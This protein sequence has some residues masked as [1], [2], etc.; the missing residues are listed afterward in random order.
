MQER[1]TEEDG[2]THVSDVTATVTRALELIGH[3]AAAV[4]AN[5]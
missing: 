5:D 3:T 4:L 2:E 1:E